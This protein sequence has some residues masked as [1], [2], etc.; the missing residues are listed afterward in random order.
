MKRKRR[1]SSVAG[2]TYSD[3]TEEL[4]SQEASQ[5]EACNNLPNSAPASPAHDN[6]DRRHALETHEEEE[7]EGELSSSDSSLSEA[8]TS[9]SSISSAEDLEDEPQTKEDTSPPPC[10]RIMVVPSSKHK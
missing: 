8:G 9:L 1:V 3:V 10:M 6:Q 7:E 5:K 4:W 2:S